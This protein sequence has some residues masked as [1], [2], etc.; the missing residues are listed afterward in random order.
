MPTRKCILPMCCLLA[1]IMT[2]ASPGARAGHPFNMISFFTGKKADLK[3]HTCDK[4]GRSHGK[5]EYCIA[6]HKVEE[7][8]VGK[9]EV[10]DTKIKYEWV[11]IPETRYRWK[12][13]LITEEVSCPYCC[14]PV[15]ETED[16]ERC[17]GREAWE[18]HGDECN[19]LH[20]RHIEPIIEKAETKRCEHEE[21]ETTVKVKYWSCVKVPYTVYRQVKQPVGV[22]Q[23]RYKKAK[24]SITRYVCR[25][26]GNAG[27]NGCDGG[28]YAI[29]TSDDYP[30]AAYDSD[31]DSGD[32]SEAGSKGDSATD[33]DSSVDSDS[34]TD[35]DAP[36]TLPAPS[37]ADPTEAA[38]STMPARLPPVFVNKFSRWDGS[39]E[40]TDR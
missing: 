28:G 11:S 17:V 39:L 8:V 27:C 3:S 5:D 20:C 12:K 36:E 35:P 37:N 26:C 21:G 25:H 7:C 31:T 32:D 40:N 9:K 19:E 6:R 18:K 16:C 15:L 33:A 4:C 1:L 24:V 13:Q 29:P 34:D 14:K 30:D 10:F 23:P 22:K 2:C 38:T